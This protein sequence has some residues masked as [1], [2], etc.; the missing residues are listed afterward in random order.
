MF[1]S[2]RI[3]LTLWYVIISMSISLFFSGVIFAT[4]H[5]ELIRNERRMLFELQLMRDIHPRSNPVY[6]MK[7]NIN[8]MTERAVAFRL[9]YINGII[10]GLS[11]LAGYFLAGRTLRPIKEMVDSQNRFVADASHELR[12]P[13]TS[14]RTAIEVNLRDKS[15]TLAQAKTVLREN[16]EDVK[17]LHRLS[18]HLLSLA[19]FRTTGIHRQNSVP[20][21]EVLKKAIHAVSYQAKVKNIQ[22]TLNAADITI[23]GD[24]K[25]LEDVFV[26]FLDNAIK[27]SDE[28]TA[29]IVTMKK[30]DNRAIISITDQGIGIAKK[31]IAHIFD[32]FFRADTSRSTV[33]A[34]GY[35]LG[36]AIAKEVIE[37]HGGKVEVK[38]TLHKGTEFTISLPAGKRI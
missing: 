34:S 37:A 31:D 19:R 1:H 26:I 5:D 4:L 28:K 13:L 6:V 20:L 3:K 12:T 33:N 16:L 2:V 23:S 35:G 17:K 36:L 11:S 18:E 22:I 24:E 32:R 38:S 8:Q 7:K 29:V 27:Y 30:T 10:L 15:M 21:L 14:L 25:R 9:L